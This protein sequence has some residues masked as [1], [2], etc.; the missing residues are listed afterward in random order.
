[1]VDPRDD[2]PVT[3]PAQ[4]ATGPS[5]VDTALPDPRLPDVERLRLVNLL[6]QGGMGEV[7]SCRDGHLGRE[8]AFKRATSPDAS[9]QARFVREA[10]VQGQ[11]EHPGIVPVHELGLRD[12]RLFFTMKR[13]RGV[14]LGE[15]LR[16][17]GEGDAETRARFPRFKL[18][19]V[20]AA[21]AR[22]LDFAHARGVVH[23]DLK[24]GN[25]M[26][27]DYGEVYL[28]D[29]G[30]AKV[31]AAEDARGSQEIVT[32]PD[33]TLAGAVMGTPG[34]MAPEQAAGQ[35]ATSAS[36]VWA[37]GAVLFELL[38][39]APL[40]E[41]RSAL[42]LLAATQTF[43]ARAL[44][45][46]PSTA[47]VAP[48]LDALLARALSPAPGARPTARQF[49]EG[50]DDVLSGQRDVELR[51]GLAARHAQ[52]ARAAADRALRP[53]GE[54]SARKEALQEV[55]RALALQPG[56]P[57]AQQT[58]AALLQTPPSVQ[59]P[60]VK[61]ELERFQ[62]RVTARGSRNGVTGYLAIAPFMLF[63]LWMGVRDVPSLV[64]M[65]VPWFVLMA[66]SVWAVRSPKT[67]RAL[68]LTVIVTASLLTATQALVV[69]P[70]MVIPSAASAN[71]MALTMWVRTSERVTVLVFSALSVLA[72]LALQAL[73]LV[74]PFYRF[75]GGNLVV[76][77]HALHLAELPT[78][79]MLVVA[80]LGTMII[81]SL[82]MQ[83]LR[84]SL[85]EAQ[86]QL[87]LQRWTLEQL[88]G[89]AGEKP[90]AAPRR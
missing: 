26:L 71:A 82:S 49:A 63:A 48:E 2:L 20:A 42:E 35:A 62:D 43:K 11:L 28:L 64:V 58:F 40:L 84:D 55:G 10:R 6:G 86:A 46:E 27:G 51:E 76:V 73:G 31:G 80:A 37:L 88:G 78:M 4:P 18:L 41:G 72:P 21:L 25:V 17:L 29:W 81:P 32:Q 61:E 79:I 39:L 1:M 22:T 7:W 83:R 75:D 70:L 85:D 8:L 16:R 52:R 12:G 69:G 34:Y 90:G 24:P 19:A 66:A 65:C 57:L 59:P 13:V 23:R 5:P 33:A 36:D 89:G 30:L 53:G 3:L 68:R 67:T 74:E 47:D 15:V 14:T 56:Q 87:S 77:P 45:D 60:E 54:L 9:A 44:R 50:L 38:T